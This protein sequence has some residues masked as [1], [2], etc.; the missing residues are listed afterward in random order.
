MAKLKMACA[1]AETALLAFMVAPSDDAIRSKT[2]DG[3]FTSWNRGAE[4]I[5]GYVAG[6]IVGKRVAML[7]PP[8]RPDDMQ[9]ILDRVRNGER[10]E[11]YETV[12]VRK[13]GQSIDVSLTGSP[14]L[15]SEGTLIG[16]SSIG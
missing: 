16:I 8:D 11:H 3:V 9:A 10:V 1:D 12:R 13:D 15:D 2:L 6:E 5:Y 4:K 7:I 14:S